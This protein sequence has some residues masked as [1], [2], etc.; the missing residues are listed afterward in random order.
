M[1]HLGVD[2]KRR[3]YDVISILVAVDIVCRVQ[4]NTYRWN[5]KEGLPRWFAE[6]QRLGLEEEAAKTDSGQEPNSGGK[7]KGMAQICQ[8]LIQIFLVT[9][10]REIA[11]SE[12]AETILPLT[13]AELS[14]R[15]KAMR[16]MTRRLY[17][18]AN[19]LQAIGI[20]KKTRMNS[21]DSDS[22]PGFRWVYP[23]RPQDM[24]NYL[25]A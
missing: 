25:G 24:H 8:K 17:D 9:G 1:E 20:L 5:G 19:L 2:N 4:C 18:I 12:A 3:V 15:K 23:I 16:Q 21:K 11:L 13:H 10:R 7:I 14:D 22:K 6:L